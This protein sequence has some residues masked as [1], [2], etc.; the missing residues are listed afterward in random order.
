MRS[1]DNSLVQSIPS[2]ST[3]TTPLLASASYGQLH[4]PPHAS[5]SGGAG[6]AGGY[7]GGG[8]LSPMAEGITELGF[9]YLH[10]IFIQQGRMETTWTVLRKFG[11]GEGLDLREDF[12]LPK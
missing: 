11:Y 4:Q 9:L 6:G 2:F 3:P 5:G 1:Y 8:G 7:G 12:L 10:T